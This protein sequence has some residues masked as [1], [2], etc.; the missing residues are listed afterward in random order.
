MH[1]SKTL[2]S[3]Q[4][5]IK[6]SADCEAFHKIPSDACPASIQHAV[7]LLS[8]S[9]AHADLTKASIQCATQM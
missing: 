4:N 6:L 9:P 1:I 2:I 5:Q 8:T 3:S 7:A